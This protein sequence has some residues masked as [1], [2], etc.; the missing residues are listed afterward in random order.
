MSEAQ[1]IQTEMLLFSVDTISCNMIIQ[2]QN[3]ND[4]DS[5]FSI[6]I[7]LNQIMTTV[8]CYFS[9]ISDFLLYESYC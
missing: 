2:L 7:L 1:E 6:C 4:I 5:I 3:E 9:L 8:I